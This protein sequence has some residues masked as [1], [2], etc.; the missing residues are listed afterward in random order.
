MEM[1]TGTSAT[2][3]REKGKIFNFGNNP[4]DIDTNNFCIQASAQDLTFFTKPLSTGDS[5]GTLPFYPSHSIS[6]ISQH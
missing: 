3:L 5:I 2:S 1:F 4:T 6:F